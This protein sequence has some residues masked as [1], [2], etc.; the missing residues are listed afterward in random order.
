ML[1]RY[2]RDNIAQEIYLCNV[3][4][5][6]TVIFSRENYLQNFL[7]IWLGQHC[8]RKQSV[9]CW[10]TVHKIFHRKI[11]Y[12]FVWIYLGKH[13]TRKLP[14]QCWSMANR[15]LFWGN[16]VYNVSLTRLV[17]PQVTKMKFKA[18]CHDSKKQFE[19]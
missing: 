8:I 11:V 6:H 1:S 18:K 7:L 15:E 4:P 2:A 9:Q 17:Q 3:G 12:N 10:P 19:K 5:K 16:I 14:V 13:C